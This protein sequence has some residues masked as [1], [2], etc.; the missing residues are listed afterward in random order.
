MF[1]YVE[2]D[3]FSLE[4]NEVPSSV[5]G[6]IMVLGSLS[7]LCSGFCSCFARELLWCVLQWILLVLGSS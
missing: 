5:Y 2:L 6:F 3:L 1:W 7:F 4:C